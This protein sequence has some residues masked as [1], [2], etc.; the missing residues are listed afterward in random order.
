MLD[1]RRLRTLREVGARGSFSAAAEALHFTQA[2]VSQQVA[3]LERE[4]GTLLVDRSAR[5]LRLTDAGRALVGRTEA[6]LG[7]LAAAQADLEAIRGLRA[8]RLR[9][10]F[11]SSAGATILAPA[12]ATFEGRHPGVEV[13]VQEGSGAA[14]ASLV[15]TG[16]LDVAILPAYPSETTTEPLART[17]ILDDPF[18]LLLPP[19]HRLARRRKVPLAALANESFI[20]PAPSGPVAAEYTR[21]LLRACARAGFEPKA[22]YYITDCQTAQAFVAASLGIAIFPELA[23]HPVNPGVET[24]RLADGPPSRTIVAAHRR[25]PGPA[26]EAFLETVGPAGSTSLAS[27]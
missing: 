9:I 12:V 18:T 1:L 16:E 6:V 24:R 26:A 11:F 5:P 22:A 21:V 4:T 19:G 14:L 25:P 7:E 3:L 27:A 17:P 23:L 20:V 2:A 8:G 15:R 10:G 13:H